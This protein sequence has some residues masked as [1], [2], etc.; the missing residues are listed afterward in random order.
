M[1]SPKLLNHTWEFVVLIERMFF[2]VLF[3]LKA[4]VLITKVPL[5]IAS[6]FTYF[7]PELMAF[8]LHSFCLSNAL[9]SVYSGFVLENLCMLNAFSKALWL[10]CLLYDRCHS[11]IVVWTLKLMLLYLCSLEETSLLLLWGSHA[12][13]CSWKYLELCI[14]ILLEIAAFRL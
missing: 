8:S 3:S 5:V 9:S 1:F 10:Y 2:G 13:D 12:I 14:Y 6:L 11:E 7:L 4:L